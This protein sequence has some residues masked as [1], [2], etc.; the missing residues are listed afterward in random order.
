[1]LRHKYVRILFV[2]VALITLWA[3]LQ[4][5]LPWYVYVL[6][7]L[8]FISI[9][10]F[11]S[12]YIRAN[13]YVSSF[14]AA[15]RSLKS[16]AITFDDGPSDKGTA[17]ILDILKKEKVP[18]LFF[19]IGK[20]VQGRQE[21]LK[22][23]DDEGHIIG[24]HSFSHNYWF[25]LK[26]GKDMLADLQLCD[27]EVVEVLGKKMRLFRPPY[28]VTNPMVRYAVEKGKYTSVG[29]SLRSFD[30]NATDGKA[31]LHSILNKLQGGDVILLHDWGQFTAAI[32]PELIHKIREKG[33]EIQRADRLLGIEPYF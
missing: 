8:P 28:G 3:G 1:M 16:V 19:V 12:Y 32:L 20:N 13:Y 22:R 30:T 7:V 17:L 10:A 18:A 9:A 2:A 33:Y 15:A 24:N 26:S 14:N 31:L 21:I 29:W 6:V 4:Y 25:S 27:K 23:A 5:H 11:G